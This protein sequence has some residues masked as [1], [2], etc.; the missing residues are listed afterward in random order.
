[1]GFVGIVLLTLFFGGVVYPS[2]PTGVPFN[3]WFNKFSPK[4]GLDLQGGAH[5]VYEADVSNISPKD[6]QSALE[7]VRDVIER[8]VNAF[9][10]SEPL[11]QTN[12]VGD[13][14]RVIIELAGVFDVNE[15][16][17]LIGETPLLEFKEQN[18]KAAEA[19]RQ[20][21]EEE[22]KQME[23][24]N[25]QA[26]QK[27]QGIIARIQN[28]EDFAQ[29]A[30]ELSEDPGSKDKGGDLGFVKRGVMVPEFENVLF[31]QLKDGKMTKTPVKTQFGY[32]II[33][34]LE[35]RGSGDSL[36]V[37]SRHILI[38]TKS[39][40]DFVPP[41]DPWVNTGLSGKHLKRAQLVFDQTTGAPQ[42]SLEFNAEGKELFS[43]ITKR[44]LQKPVAIF[45]DGQPLSVPIVQSVITNGEAVISG[46]FTIASAKTLA[47]RLNAGALPVPI[48]LVSQQRVGPSLGHE[49]VVTS[50]KAGFWGLIL[51]MIFMVVVY[52]L[53]G[54]LADI[55]LAIYAIVVIGLFEVIPITLT[56]AGI[57]GFILSVGMAVDANILIFERMKE[58]LKMGKPL[59]KAIEEGFKRAWTSIRDS[60]ISSLVTSAILFWFGTSIIKGFALTLSIGILVSMF[61]AITVTRTFL[62]LV[63]TPRLKSATWLFG[64]KQKKEKDEGE[65]Q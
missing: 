50:V 52:R 36:E 28:G 42:V 11:V 30:K 6:R 15:A 24:Y 54:F 53:P 23:E 65:G 57:A 44:N 2:V 8:R 58:E 7:G 46:D 12:K 17:R 61:S 43:E 35:S 51:V 34:R 19:S 48:Q 3:G 16:I 41:V 1:M 55:A 40:A 38:R 33:Q 39:K 60:N 27:A 59:T 14:Y 9:G 5:L 22:K 29:L 4:L 32:H 18:P 64:I 45:L 56:L 20:L 63:A 47:K 62:L 31:D 13:S 26:L 37:R 49:S 10:V 21:T 25:A